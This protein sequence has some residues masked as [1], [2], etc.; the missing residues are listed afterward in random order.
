VLSVL[1]PR[2]RRAV[3][4][5]L[6]AVV[7]GALA[8]PGVA[9]ADDGVPAATVVGELVQGYADPG[10]A[11]E[12]DAH[13]HDDGSGLLSWVQTEDGD[14]VRVPTED[15][16]DID[17]GATIQ[18]TVGR[19]VRDEASAEG[20]EP[21]RAVVSSEVLAAADEP[22]TASTAAPVNHEVTVVM[23]QPA[24]TAA[25]RAADPTTL[26]Q[27]VTAV[28]GPV[29]DFWEQQSG[30]A[31]R[32][33]VVASFDWATTTAS[34]TRPFDL[35]QAAAARAGWTAGAGKHLLVYVPYDSPGCSYGL[36]TVGGGLDDGGLAYV[37]G[38]GTSV[39][40]H[41]FGH[42]LGLGHS[43][44]LQCDQASEESTSSACQLASYRDYYDVMGFSWSQLGTLNAL[45]QGQLG[46]LPADQWRDL[47]VDGPGEVR[48]QPLTAVTGLRAVR[49]TA[50]DG[51]RYWL[52]NRT[53]AGRDAWLSTTGAGI[54]LQAGVLVRREA[55]GEGDS[56]L[57]LD[58]TPSR[59]SRW[60]GDLATALPVG[61]PVQIASGA[62]TLTLTGQDGGAAVVTVQTD[63]GPVLARYAASGG[64]R[65]VLGTATGPETCG[66]RD[67]GCFRRYR[68]GVVYWT[69]ATGA[70][71]AVGLV[72]QRWAA[73]GWEWGAL[74]Y[75]VTDTMCGLVRG[76]CF[77]HFQGG[78]IYFSV[79]SGVQLTSGAIRDR[80]EALG[81]ENGMLGYPVGELTCGARNGGCLQE[82]QYGV[83]Y[84]QAATGA[85]AVIGLIR[86]RWAAQGWEWGALGYPV[87]DTVC[88]LV[89]G[90]CFQH[91][92]GGSIYFSPASGVQVTS[93]AIRDRWEALGWE[94]GMLGYPVGPVTCGLRADGCV[95]AFQ[96]GIV[97]GTP[98]NSYAVVGLVLDR[99]TAL[100]RETGRLGYPVMD[101]TCGLVAGGCYQHFDSGS[102]Y[103]SPAGGVHD[104]YGV[105]RDRWAA[106][107]WEHGP[108]G[109]P[110][111]NLSCGLAGGTCAQTFQGGVIRWSPQSG[112]TGVG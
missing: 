111:G 61:V 6:A 100:G 37:E 2:S 70:H 50:P 106:S 28:N 9:R 51:S 35:W 108:L 43:S 16:A 73:Q 59:T 24:G 103:F 94:N 30:G 72:W 14:A 12:D 112:Q 54:G 63:A 69:P 31:V 7:G 64:A 92:Q 78:S 40:A 58:P 38:S 107:G 97:S 85:H 52:E 18:V 4:A 105:V 8:V 36:G 49:L 22:A 19:T 48:L 3:G 65:G 81:W 89:R 109:Y 53:S 71:L 47:T 17:A 74:G 68:D 86:Q 11:R 20:L 45:Q 67:G 55:P 15:V 104:V 39:I 21:A 87:T 44:E 10:P 66:L 13:P 60:G 41:E 88:G 29:R 26:S 25:Q 76:G 5:L 46:V 23:M 57:L 56:S 77:Q 90:G 34:C 102:L 99:W 80:W 62:F 32:F 95:Q 91:F 98:A 83:V 27:I 33:G 42:N 75:P 79:A 110:T 96:G 93:G 1:S 82:F 84:T 101:T